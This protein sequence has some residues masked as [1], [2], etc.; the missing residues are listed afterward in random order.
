[1]IQRVQRDSAI[2]TRR[3]VTDHIS[4][5]GMGKFMNSQGNGH[6]NHPRQHHS[7]IKVSTKYLIN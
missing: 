1:M 4:D 7:Q 2:Q 3:G 5:L 6:S